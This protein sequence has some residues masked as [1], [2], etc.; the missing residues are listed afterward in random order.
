MR[1]REFITLLGSATAWPAAAL[2]Q[3][4]V[5]HPLIGFLQSGSKEATAFWTSAFSEGMRDHGYVEGQSY[6]IAYRFADDDAA[7][8]PALAEELVQLKPDVIVASNTTAA[9]AAKKAT[10]SIPIV[11]PILAG[12]VNLGLVTSHAR[13]GGNVTGILAFIDGLPGKQVE[14][15]LE[16]IPTATKL[17]VLFN[18]TNPAGTA[19]RQE[20]EAAG[21]AKGIKVV[22]AKARTKGDLDP[23][24]TSLTAAGVQV[25][26][27]V[28][29]TLL[30]GERVHIAELAAAAHLPTVA[31]IAEHAKAGG[32]IAYGI[33]TPANVRRAAYFVDKML[34]GAKASDLPVELPTKVELVINLKTAKALGLSIAPSLLSRA[35]EVIE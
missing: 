30:L 29:D 28:R 22:A 16:L 35:D 25:V 3:T 12:A 15:A 6:D 21:A 2:A 1:R 11:I 32:L 5:K 20:I 9:L 8:L 27:V 4:A 31:G 33:S 26:I 18:P 10:Q 7:R 14:I 34:K 19:Q 24:F 13:P 17:G 23:A